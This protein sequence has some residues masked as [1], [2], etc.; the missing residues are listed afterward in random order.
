MNAET[1]ATLA[2]RTV[3]FVEGRFDDFPAEDYHAI[4][5]M[6]TG[7]AKKILRSPAHFRLARDTPNEPTDAM[8]FGTAVHCGVLEPDDFDAR[9]CIAPEVNKR[10]NAGKA[11]WS[12]FQQCNEGKIILSADDMARA[13]K[14]I[15]AVRMH[16]AAQRL[17]EGG[18]NEVSLFWHDGRY[19]VP[20]KCRFDIL[21]YGGGVDLKTTQDASPEGFGR[22]I[23]QYLYHAQGAHYNSGAEHI[24][25]ASLE[26]FAFIAVESEPPHCVACYTLPTNA[27]LAG[28]RLIAE[29]LARYAAALDAGKWP[30]YPETI[31]PIQLPRW[32]TRFD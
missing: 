20:C 32:A 28:S 25:N 7:G 29:A 15:D 8:E 2:K 16:P 1:P 26:F 5:A 3:P 31:Q 27:M 14:C 9:I 11:E 6:S 18:Q 4:E 24:L 13:R 17:L 22:S 19:K 23:A 12:Y 10:T 30:G 21:N